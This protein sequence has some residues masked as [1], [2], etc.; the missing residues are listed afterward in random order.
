MK[1]TAVDQGEDDDAREVLVHVGLVDHV[2]DQI[3][4]ER[5]AGGGNAH[6]AERRAHSAAIGR[7]PA[8]AAAGGP[9]RRVPLGS[10][11]RR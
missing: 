3:G 2:A 6:Q 10:A 7:P 4:A 9:G 8:P 5:G 1:I 11:N